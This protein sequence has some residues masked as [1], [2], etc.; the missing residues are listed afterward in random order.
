MYSSTNFVICPCSLE[1]VISRG[2]VTNRFLSN[3][4]SSSFCLCSLFPLMPRHNYHLVAPQVRSLCAKYE[5][6][7]EV[8]TLWRGL[9]D[10]VRCVWRWWLTVRLKRCN[11]RLHLTWL[12]L[13]C[14]AVPLP[15]NQKKIFFSISFQVTEELR[16]PL[17]WCLS[18]Q[19]IFFL[20]SN[21]DVFII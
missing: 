19:M 12:V 11:V 5:I 2:T 17:A 15:F 1:K 16:R 7:Y 13:K 20:K 9:A 14:A 4:S 18:P 3:E 6:P 10:V 8:K 21:Y